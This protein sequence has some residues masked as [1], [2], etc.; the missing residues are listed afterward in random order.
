MKNMPFTIFYAEIVKFGLML[1]IC[2]YSG[3]NLGYKED[4]LG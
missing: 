4:I 2:H 1:S 3:E